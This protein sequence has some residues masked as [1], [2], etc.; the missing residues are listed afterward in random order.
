MSQRIWADR[1][2]KGKE[3]SEEALASSV[4]LSAKEI[5]DTFSLPSWVAELLSQRTDRY[6][7]SGMED[8]ERFLKPSL[9]HLP[10]P[11]L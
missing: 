11:L 4:E 9:K 5:S 1:T 7:L 2:S 3:P 10:D 6:E 8:V